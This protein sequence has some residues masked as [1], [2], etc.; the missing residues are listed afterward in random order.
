MHKNNLP[1][2]KIKLQ[3]NALSGWESHKKMAPEMRLHF[4][5]KMIESKNPKYASVLILIYPNKKEELTILLTKRAS[6]NGTH[7]AQISFPG[8]KKETNDI[9]LIQTALREAKEETNIN[10]KDLIFVK[11]L[12]KTYIPPSNFWV[13]PFVFT[14]DKKPNFKPNHEVEH[15]IEISLSDLLDDKKTTIKKLSTSYM[16]N[17]D[18]P[19]F[20]FN[21]EIVW[22]ATAMILSELK[23]LI[24]Q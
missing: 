11:E 20:V 2:L 14:T 24:K 12:S 19:C 5:D 16:K 22:G 15:I 3:K 21:N 13:Y 18:V 8:G 10:P 6:Y 23:D 4:T 1:N 7:S 17:I 9:N